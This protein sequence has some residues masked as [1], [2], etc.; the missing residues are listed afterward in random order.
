MAPSLQSLLDL[1]NRAPPAAL[2]HVAERLSLGGCGG[3]T[4]AATAALQAL[5]PTVV[6]KR[7]ALELAQRAAEA[8]ATHAN[9]ARDAEA[10]ALAAEAAAPL[11]AAATQRGGNP[12]TAPLWA[13]IE[14]LNRLPRY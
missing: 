7:P 1:L 12:L 10:A 9:A 6:G 8:L 3:S 13:L 2:C 14:R 4:E 11:F 5:L